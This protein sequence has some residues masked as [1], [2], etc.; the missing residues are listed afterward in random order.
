MLGYDRR[1]LAVGDT[2]WLEDFVPGGKG[3]GP[4]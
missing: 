3:D 4:E 1:N 2:P